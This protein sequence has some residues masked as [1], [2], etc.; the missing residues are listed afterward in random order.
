MG[1]AQTLQKF[2]SAAAVSYC[3]EAAQ[4]DVLQPSLPAPGGAA[5]PSHTIISPAQ[6][7]LMEL[8]LPGPLQG[9]GESTCSPRQLQWLMQKAKR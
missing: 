2:L 6:G 7:C 8:V 1:K 4:E 3:T 5:A 9:E